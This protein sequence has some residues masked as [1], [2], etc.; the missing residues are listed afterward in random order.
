MREYDRDDTGR[1]EFQ[2]FMDISNFDIK[3]KFFKTLK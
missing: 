2:D 3:I 1:I